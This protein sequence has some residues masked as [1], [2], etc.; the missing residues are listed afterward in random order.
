MSQT[1]SDANLASTEGETR[2]ARTDRGA[3]RKRL[4]EDIAFL[5]VQQYRRQL[6]GA[7]GSAVPDCTDSEPK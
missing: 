7:A 3:E 1:D 5:V 6:R 4:A 2:D